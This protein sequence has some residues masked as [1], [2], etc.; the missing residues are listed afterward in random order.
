M[1]ECM[2]QLVESL[3]KK[4]SYQGPEFMAYLKGLEFVEKYYELQRL[5]IEEKIRRLKELEESNE[6][7]V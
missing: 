6:I 3:S 5:V 7:S 4:Q 1:E 2:F